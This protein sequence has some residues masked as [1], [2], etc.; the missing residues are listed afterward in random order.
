MAKNNLTHPRLITPHGNTYMGHLGQ[1]MA[2][3][4]TAPSQYRKQFWLIFTLEQF[5]SAF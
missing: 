1:V 4:L 5:S 2:S 3:N